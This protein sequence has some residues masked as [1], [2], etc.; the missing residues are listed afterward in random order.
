[1]QRSKKAHSFTAHIWN[2]MA[3]HEIDEESATLK[4]VLPAY[5][6]N[7][8]HHQALPPLPPLSAIE[9]KHRRPRVRRTIAVA[10]IGILTT[11]EMILQS[12]VLLTTRDELKQRPTMHMRDCER[13]TN[14]FLLVPSFIWLNGNHDHLILT[15]GC[16]IFTKP[17]DVQTI[18]I[19]KQSSEHPLVS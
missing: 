18:V 9:S 19:K 11:D 15:P 17:K 8:N 7:S 3:T 14:D 2:T 6:S 4:A 5:S 10:V 16:Y 12:D 1:M 13:I